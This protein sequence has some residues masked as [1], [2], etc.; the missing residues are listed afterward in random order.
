MDTN[1]SIAMIDEHVRVLLREP[2]EAPSTVLYGTLDK[3][4]DS[5]RPWRSLTAYISESIQDRDVKF[6]KKMFTQF[7]QTLFF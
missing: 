7:L 3:P 1:N 2:R 6:W 5:S 4:T